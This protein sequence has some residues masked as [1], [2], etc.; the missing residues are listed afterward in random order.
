MC[1][2]PAAVRG[3]LL[4]DGY[5]ILHE[6]YDKCKLEWA[7]GG[8][9]ADQH[10][11][12]VEFFDVLVNAGIEPIVILDGGGTEANIHDTIHRRNEEIN[13]IP[14]QLRKLHENSDS[15]DYR[16]HTLPLLS[17]EVYKAS[18]KHIEKLQV[19]V[20]DGKARETVVSLANHYG[21]PVLTNNPNY[22]VSGVSGGVIFFKYFNSTTCSA[23]VYKQAEL[24]RHLKLRNPDLI[25]AIV[26]IM[27]DGSKTSIPFLYHGRIKADIQSVCPD[28]RSSE[29][30]WVLNIVDYLNAKHIHSF[31]HFK[32]QVMKFNFGR[33]QCQDLAENCRT[34]EEVFV[35]LSRTI[36][37]ETLMEST[38]IASSMTELPTEIVRKYRL[39]NYP[40]TVLSAVCVGKC[41]LDIY[42]GD[43]D[44]PPVS[45][46]G[47]Q[48][49]Q[50][51]YGLVI[52]L[53]A[54]VIRRGVDE[55]YRS[56]ELN[57]TNKLWEYAAHK[58]QPILKYE[59]LSTEKIFTLDNVKRKKA[60]EMA[61]CDVLTSPPVILLKF[62]RNFD[63]TYLLAIL[64]TH[65]WAQHLLQQQELNQP[66]QLIKSLVLNF[67]IRLEE[68]KKEIQ[69]SLYSNPSWIKVY[70]ALLEWQALYRDVC[71][72]NSM[73]LCP[74]LELHPTNIL[75]SSFVIELALHPDP[76][77]TATFQDRMTKEQQDLYDRII[78]FFKL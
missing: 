40:E 63:S 61:I 77:I 16:D 39:G 49:R 55:Y 75:D 78:T 1:T 8:C 43:R 41:T 22:C 42:V 29:R 28:A 26:A 37:V 57:S 68:D 60:A 13:D 44:Q 58:I 59:N 66:E 48:V 52:P 71:G 64:A 31:Q 50:T 9:Y 65:Y 51:M 76:N 45:R 5:S 10:K 38:T 12:T 32:S 69:Q 20:A 35:S 67:F 34:I 33:K 6:L 27:G 36:A 25:L 11:A 54:R 47:L 73:L 4:V 17:K 24:V 30:P 21:C 62:N 74:F 23:P 56:D 14:G 18:L 15:K 19:V 72:L 2:A 46:L 70:H 7:S 53:M 3:K